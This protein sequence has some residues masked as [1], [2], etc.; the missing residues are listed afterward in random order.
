[1]IHETFPH[2]ELQDYWSSRPRYDEKQRHDEPSQQAGSSQQASSSGHQLVVENPDEPPPPPYTLE[3]DTPSPAP[4][5]V[6]TPAVPQISVASMPPPTSEASRPDRNPSLSRHSS[7][8]ARPETRYVGNRLSN[9][10][11]RLS[12]SPS[13]SPQPPPLPPRSTTPMYPPQSINPPR[14]ASV[15]EP[16]GQPE[17]S[18]PTPT[19]PSFDSVYALPQSH[20]THAPAQQNDP[21]A[22]WAQ[23]QD[24]KQSTYGSS[25]SSPPPPPLRTRPTSR[26]SPEVLNTSYNGYPDRRRVQSS[27]AAFGPP[28]F[29]N[30]PNDMSFPQAFDSGGALPT[31]NPSQGG[32][33]AAY[34]QHVAMYGKQSPP[35]IEGGPSSLGRNSSIYAPPQQPQQQHIDRPGSAG[36]VSSS[37]TPYDPNR[38]TSPGRNSSTYFP[39]DQAN[40]PLSGG[41]SSSNYAPLSTAQQQQSTYPSTYPSQ[42]S[43]PPYPSGPPFR[44]YITD[45]HW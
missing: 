12:L 4:Q 33:Y 23:P 24:Q 1:M 17:F 34:Q 8:S 9:D 27:A 20:S 40:R 45:T 18:L 6:E 16:F 15:P 7:S 43:N 30:T 36:R 44:G 37:Y 25:Y 35:L 39:Y 11:A 26:P 38:P 3:D 13:T 31:A 2:K 41:P 29:H 21:Y 19:I 5:A 10:M 14:R 22:A 42:S 32:S 28:S